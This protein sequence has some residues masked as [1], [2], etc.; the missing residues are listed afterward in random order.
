M[1][2]LIVVLSYRVPEITID[3]LRSLST[4]IHRVPETRVALLEN[5]SGG[6]TAER[7]RT[8]IQEN[9]WNSWVDFTELDVNLGFT[10]GN[11]FLIR[12]A[13]ES[14]KPPDYFLLLNSDTV[15]CEHALDALVDFMDQHPKAG[16]AGSR[17]L[18]LDGTVRAS[19]FRFPGILNELDRG[20]GL[21]IVSK[22]L[23]PWALEP[24]KP[25]KPTRADWVSGASMMVRRKTFEEIGLLDEGYFTYFEDVDFAFRA[26]KAGWET[27]YVT[28]SPVVHLGGASSGIKQKSVKRLP[29]FWYQARRRYFLK[30]NGKIGTTLADAA[31]I[32]G[33]TLKR[34]R[35]WIQGTSDSSPEHMLSDSIRESVFR[36]GW[37]LNYVENP[38]PKA[39]EVARELNKKLTKNGQLL[40]EPQ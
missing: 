23:S 28:D 36:A 31:F 5:G 30:N 20:L 8:A 3:C 32:T 33:F 25:N 10:G 6:D 39:R 24:P 21:G 11:N 29:A 15:V 38:D 2:L 13:L 17:M 4:E 34:L 14:E 19:P 37:K 18:R 1:K 35:K 22:L 12:K 7:I 40:G 9:S 16:I 27:W 26:K